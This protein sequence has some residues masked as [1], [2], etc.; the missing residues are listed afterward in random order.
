MSETCNSASGGK[1]LA[2]GRADAERLRD[3]PTTWETLTGLATVVLLLA[4]GIGAED[5]LLP[6]FAEPGPTIGNLVFA[7]SSAVAPLGF[8]VPIWLTRRRATFGV[9]GLRGAPL[10]QY[11]AWVPAALILPFLSSHAFRISAE[12]MGHAVEPIIFQRTHAWFDAIGVVPTIVIWSGAAGLSL[13]IAY[14]GV[15]LPWLRRWLP[16]AACA[17]ILVAL[18]MAWMS[19]IDDL[20]YATFW[21]TATILQVLAWHRSGSLYLILA[22]GLALEVAD[23][24]SVFVHGV[25]A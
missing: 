11:A 19:S 12:A 25:G 23:L 16:I 18:D 2:G 17:L 4:A 20:V 10:V 14:F 13:T 22:M 5:W 1:L 15:I 7:V 6:T 9:I 21:A 3:P 24:V 8:L